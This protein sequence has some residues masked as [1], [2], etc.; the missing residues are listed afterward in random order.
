MNADTFN[1]EMRKY[2]KRVGVTSQRELENVVQEALATGTL[3]GDET[4]KVKVVLTAEGLDLN[5]VVEGE[6]NLD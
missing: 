5:H 2:L 4:L 3:K 6:I 1:M